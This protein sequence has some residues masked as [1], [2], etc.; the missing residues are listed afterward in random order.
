MKDFWDLAFI[1]ERFDIPED[2][3]RASLKA[4]FRWRRTPMPAEP[5]VF[6]PSF[7]R[8]E[9]ALA[10]W[11]AFIRRTRLP[12]MAWESALTLIRNRLTPLYGELFEA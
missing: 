5:L 6:S 10:M 4:T 7:M 1:L 2:E 9:K 3:L 11:S 8:S 12:D